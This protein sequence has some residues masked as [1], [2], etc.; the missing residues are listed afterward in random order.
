MKTSV[1]AALALA[2]LGSTAALAADPYDK[3]GGGLKEP[4]GVTVVTDKIN[5]SG[6]Y[7]GA[8]V[9]HGTSTLSAD[10]DQGGLSLDGLFGGGRVGLDVQKG[11]LVFGIFGEY[12]FSDEAIELGGA[13]VLEKTDDWSANARVGY[14]HGATLFYLGGGYGQANFDY[15]FGYGDSGSE[16][17][18]SWNARAGIE[19]KLTNEFTLGLEGRHDW[20]DLSSIDGAPS[21]IDDEID[22]RRWSIVAVGRFTINST[23]F[24]F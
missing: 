20:Y 8:Q 4:A 2:L 24:G 7:V 5:W 16:T 9:G 19:H 6:I 3:R 12:N 22:A 10:G 21:D 15:N 23:T 14:A 13:R 11:P 18:D 1:C 17:V